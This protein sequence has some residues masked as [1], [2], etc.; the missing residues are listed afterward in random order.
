MLALFL[1][2]YG[3][4]RSIAEVFRQPDPFLGTVWLG[5]TMG[6]VLSMVMIIAG[7]LLWLLRC[8][9]AG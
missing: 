3:I 7:L 1:I 8:Q 2:G 6:Q 4:L 5:L 9:R